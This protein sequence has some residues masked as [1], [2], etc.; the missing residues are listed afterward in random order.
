MVKLFNIITEEYSKL[1]ELYDYLSDTGNMWYKFSISNISKRMGI[2]LV[3]LKEI[4]DKYDDIIIYKH[5]EVLFLS[6]D[7]RYVNK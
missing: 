2:K 4:A 7:Y 3:R 1:R 6:L 5:G